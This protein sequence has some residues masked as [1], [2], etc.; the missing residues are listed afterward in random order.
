MCLVD[1]VNSGNTGYFSSDESDDHGN[2]GYLSGKKKDGDCCLM[3][4]FCCIKYAS[5]V[6]SYPF[7]G[8]PRSTSSN[9]I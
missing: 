6:L 1:S 2:P 7:A 4:F 9:L 5:L 8:Y 3:N